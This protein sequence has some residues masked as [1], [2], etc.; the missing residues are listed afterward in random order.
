MQGN[1]SQN[2][3]EENVR[4]SKVENALREDSGSRNE[5]CWKCS[6]GMDEPGP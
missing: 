6:K 3:R 1:T 4:K 2:V 5:S